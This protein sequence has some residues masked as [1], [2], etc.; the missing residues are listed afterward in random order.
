[1]HIS[2]LS[3]TY[4]EG[5]LYNYT[6]AYSNRNTPRASVSLPR[7]DPEA[8]MHQHHPKR[9]VANKHDELIIIVSRHGIGCEIG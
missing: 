7:S 8:L 5:N 9:R 3:R 6:I 4:K 1:M 2:C